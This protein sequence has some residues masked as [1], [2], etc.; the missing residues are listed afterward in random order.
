MWDTG[1][2]CPRSRLEGGASTSRSALANTVAPYEQRAGAAA[3]AHR[4]ARPRA[5]CEH[6]AE[7]QRCGFLL[8]VQFHGSYRESK[9]RPCNTSEV[10]LLQRQLHHAALAVDFNPVPVRKIRIRI[11]V[12]AVFPT[13]AVG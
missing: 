11:P 9:G 10:V 7:R 2:P 12:S 8:N 6:A 5:G 1:G 4:E 13:R 3:I